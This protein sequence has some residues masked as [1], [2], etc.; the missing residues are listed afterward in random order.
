VTTQYACQAF[1]SLAELHASEAACAFDDTANDT[2]LSSAIDQASDMLYLLSGGRITG[3]CTKQVRPVGDYQST[4]WTSSWDGSWPWRGADMNDVGYPAGWLVRYGGVETIP[5]RGPNTTIVEVVVDGTILGAAEYGLLNGN[6]LFR[7]TG[8]WPR[9]NNLLV[10]DTA[11]DTFSITYSFGRTADLITKMATI[12]VAVELANDS[13]GKQTHL[14][15]GVTSANIQGAQVTLQDR[16]QAL[17]DGTG[18]LPMLSRFLGVYAPEMTARCGVYS[19]ELRHG[20]NLVE[21]SL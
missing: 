3:V 13:L 1:V 12:E 21:T 8:S 9:C 19:P 20:W 4:A 18:Q 2:L 10:T 11:V 16:S 5:L 6:L 17:R 7:V 14:P 15:P